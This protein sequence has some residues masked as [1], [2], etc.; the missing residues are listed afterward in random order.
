MLCPEFVLAVRLARIYR[1]REQKTLAMREMNWRNGFVESGF[2]IYRE[3][4]FICTLLKSPTQDLISMI[5]QLSSPP[6]TGHG[7]PPDR[8]DMDCHGAEVSQSTHQRRPPEM[9]AIGAGYQYCRD[10]Y[11]GAVRPVFETYDRSNPVYRDDKSA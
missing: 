10:S 5:A 8:S 4:G 3:A 9:G 6:P 2:G 11:L 7:K 1:T